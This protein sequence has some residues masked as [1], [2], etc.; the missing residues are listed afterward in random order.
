MK[1]PKSN[2]NIIMI[3]AGIL[4]CVFILCLFFYED[5]FT[6]ASSINTKDKPQKLFFNYHPTYLLSLANAILQGVIWVLLIFPATKIISGVRNEFGG[7]YAIVPTLLVLLFVL[8]ILFITM[9]GTVSKYVTPPLSAFNHNGL[10]NA[11]FIGL[12]LSTGLYF[13]LGIVIIGRISLKKIASGTY[14]IKEYIRLR[15]YQDLLL[16]FTGTILTLGVISSILYQKAFIEAGGTVHEYPVEFV[17]MFGFINT[18]LMLIF[19]LPNYFIMLDYGKRMVES[20][21]PLESEGKEVTQ[22]SFENQNI[23][24]KHLRIDLPVTEAIKKSLLI[25]SPLL[26]SLLPNLLDLF[27]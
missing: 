11:V 13:L 17:I 24:S 5:I 23:L 16:K 7:R 1:F 21:Y 18:L 26:S 27:G 14:D 22:A 4:G 20:K 19:Y 25:L 2:L 9:M 6:S 15:S 10:K 8:S 12:A 3:C